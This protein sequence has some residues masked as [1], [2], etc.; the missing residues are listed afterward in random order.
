MF[1]LNENVKC[2]PNCDAI[3]CNHN[4]GPY[5]D[6]II[7]S[8]NK[9]MDEPFICKSSFYDNS[10]RLYPGK[11]DDYYKCQEVEVYKILIN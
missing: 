10:D 3:F 8:N 1:S 7:F 9:N 2:V 6:A 4:Y 11:K 5:F